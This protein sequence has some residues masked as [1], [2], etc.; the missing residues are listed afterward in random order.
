[1]GTFPPPSVIERFL[2]GNPFFYYSSSQNHFWNRV[3][4]FVPPENHLRWKWLNHAF[5]TEMEN[6]HRKILLAQERG[7]AFMDFFSIIDRLQNNA[8]DNNLINVENVVENNQL[9]QAL[10]VIPTINRILCT[11]Q[12]SFRCLLETLVGAGINLFHL[13]EPDA[14][15][16]VKVIWH[17]ENRNIEIIQ[18]YPAS[19]SNHRAQLKNEQYG[20]YL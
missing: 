11:Y 17:F 14:V 19:R 5:E 1:M 2:N 18:L 3:E 16:G 13:P 7:W 10:T 4:S 20:F 15:G 6:R 9:I 8:A 12:T